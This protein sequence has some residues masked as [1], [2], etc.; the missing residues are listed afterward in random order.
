HFLRSLHVLRSCRF[1]LAY[2]GAAKSSLEQIMLSRPAAALSL[3][4]LSCAIAAVASITAQVPG[5]PPAGGRGQ[6]GRGGPAQPIT[7]RAARVLDGRG[8]TL[9]SGV[10]EV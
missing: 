3:F 9:D 10:I 5:Q 7:M 4:S 6:G 8:G 1:E 2:D